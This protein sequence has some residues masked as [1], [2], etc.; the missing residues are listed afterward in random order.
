MRTT[1]HLQS[2]LLAVLL[3]PLAACNM[4]S[5]KPYVEPTPPTVRCK[6][7]ATAPLPPAPK[8]DQWVDAALRLSK[9]AADW[10]VV[11]TGTVDKEREYRKIEHECI[12]KLE[13][14]GLIRQ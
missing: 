12:D 14:E 10:I 5:K 7:P 2:L 8:E 4:L 11:V 6:Q 1:V 9:E 3:L 13:A